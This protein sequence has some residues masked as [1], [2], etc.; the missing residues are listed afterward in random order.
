MK[1]NTEAYFR[2]QAVNLCNVFQRIRIGSRVAC[3]ENFEE[4][5]VPN[6]V[7]NFAQ[8]R[9]NWLLRECGLHQTLE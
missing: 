5:Q 4:P 8:L 7:G 1:Q 2:K 6:K 9:D 3:G